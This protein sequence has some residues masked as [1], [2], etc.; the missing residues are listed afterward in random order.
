MLESRH[1]IVLHFFCEWLNQPGIPTGCFMRDMYR[2]PL[3]AQQLTVNRIEGGV[4]FT[5]VKKK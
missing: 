5:L 4:N 2:M 3:K 1:H